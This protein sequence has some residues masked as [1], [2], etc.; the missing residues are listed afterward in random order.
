MQ[1][2][3]FSDRIA[4][5]VDEAMRVH[6]LSQSELATRAGV[7]SRT[8]ARL[9]AGRPV[10]HDLAIKVATAILISDLYA[11]APVD[12]FRQARAERPLTSVE[13]GVA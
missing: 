5:A 6:W 13:G 9:H 1:K 2:S 10:R 8:V 3:T 4:L 11:G 7:S 12:S